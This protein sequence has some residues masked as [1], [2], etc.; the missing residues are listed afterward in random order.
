MH[1]RFGGVL[2]IT[3]GVITER[4]KLVE[5]VKDGALVV[6]IVV[7]VSHASEQLGPPTCCEA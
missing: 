1:R 4:A 6:K 2:R 5:V 7:P 3:N